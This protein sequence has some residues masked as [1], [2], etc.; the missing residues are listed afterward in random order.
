MVYPGF[1]NCVV[2]AVG[3]GKVGAMDPQTRAPRSFSASL[4]LVLGLLALA[5]VL[6]WVMVAND[7][8]EPPSTTPTTN[9]PTT[10]LPTSTTVSTTTTT[11]TTT[12]PI[13]ERVLSSL[14]GEMSLRD[15]ALQLLVVGGPGTDLI[16][17]IDQR[18]GSSCVGGVFLTE[19]QNNWGFD[20]N[21]RASA[22]A[23]LAAARRCTVGPVVVTDAEAGLRVLKVPVEPLVHPK[24]LD[25]AVGEDLPSATAEFRSRS[26]RFAS[27]LAAA[28]VHLNLGVLADVDVDAN[29]YMARQRRSFGGDPV[30]VGALSEAMVMGHCEAGVAAVLK[31]FPN[32]GATLNDPHFGDSVSS[33]SFEQWRSFGAVPYV[34]TVAPVVMT[35]HIRYQG[36]D[37]NRPASLS[38]EITNGWLRGELGFN[39]VVITDDL[40]TMAGV[41][42]EG[43]AGARAVAA[44]EAGA[45]L[46]LFVSHSEID[47][48]V[49]SIVERASADPGF[50]A[51]VDESLD[52]LLRL[53]AA[54]GLVVPLDPA[55][56]SLC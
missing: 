30:A 4:L 18:V 35:G 16:E 9:P 40:A 14:I 8:E 41:T 50:L 23:V 36:V 17:A 13:E 31:H 22:D 49:A 54:L 56:F 21:G 1:L 53:K 7:A 20:I 29:H 43:S 48:I 25:V 2:F 11:T 28:G 27:D 19:A 26:I 10:A 55:Q 51:R 33:N 5:A 52:R 34:D 24:N 47:Q 15:K 12:L 3:A 45:D 39:G 42:V 46:V 6:V 38:S 32:Q 44:I 37:G